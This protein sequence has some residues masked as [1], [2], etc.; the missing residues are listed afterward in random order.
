[1]DENNQQDILAETENYFAWR[2]VSEGEYVYH[3]ELGGVSLHMVA[4][5]WEELVILIK[6]VP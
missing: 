2:S 5:E 3:L 1:M 6:S 4:D